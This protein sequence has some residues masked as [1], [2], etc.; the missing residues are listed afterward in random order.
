MVVITV[1]IISTPSDVSLR[2]ILGE[3]D[4]FEACCIPRVNV[5]SKGLKAESVF[6]LRLRGQ[7]ALCWGRLFP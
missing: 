2:R 5:V 1:A 3:E 6:A 7:K 4:T